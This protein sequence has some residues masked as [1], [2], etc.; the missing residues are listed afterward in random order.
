M[1]GLLRSEDISTEKDYPQIDEYITDET[2]PLGKGVKVKVFK[3]KCREDGGRV[4]FSESDS[5][6]KLFEE[7]FRR[8]LHGQE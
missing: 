8:I 2:D 6:Q 7:F 4:V 3:A 1:P 5:E